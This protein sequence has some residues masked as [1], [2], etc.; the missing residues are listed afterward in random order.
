MNQRV[1]PRIF[2]I[3]GP[4]LCTHPKIIDLER[5]D[6]GAGITIG[7]FERRL[8]F[9]LGKLVATP[10][11]LAALQK[12]GESPAEFLAMHVRRQWGDLGSIF[13]G[14][15]LRPTGHRPFGDVSHWGAIYG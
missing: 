13:D 9:P 5:S 8:L 11:A 7:Q 15:N 12:A 4:S 10:G 6:L 3:T 1:W 2:D 14:S